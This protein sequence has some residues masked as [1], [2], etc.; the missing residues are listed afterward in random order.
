MRS[1]REFPSAARRSLARKERRRPRPVT[2]V[3]LTVT[4]TTQL[5]RVLFP[6]VYSWGER[7]S[8]VGV[9]VFALILFLAPVLTPV[10]IRLMGT[11][12]A[13]TATI[14]ALVAAR[15]GVQWI[16]PVPL[17]LAA[18][19]SAFALIALTLE[20]ETFG[21]STRNGSLG[22]ALGV[23]VGL[24]LDTALRSAFWTWDYAR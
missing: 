13:L 14:T 1:A 18:L 4:V 8:F 24:A 19:A 6:I 2:L 9:G 21:N 15:L 23:I 10:V 5:V 20:L 12:R 22:L 17:W 3:A 11:R 7:T 16:H